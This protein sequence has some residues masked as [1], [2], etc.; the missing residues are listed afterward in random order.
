MAETAR[1]H[2]DKQEPAQ[3]TKQDTMGGCLT[4]F[5]WMAIGNAGLL[6]LAVFIAQNASGWR[7]SWRDG[8][9]VCLVVMLAVARFVDVTRLDGQTVEGKPATVNDWRR[10]AALLAGAAAVM[11]LAAH[12]AASGGVLQ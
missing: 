7:L 8:A 1:R 3:N 6:F 2:P 4:R 5:F 11:W 10:Y 12:W 9:F